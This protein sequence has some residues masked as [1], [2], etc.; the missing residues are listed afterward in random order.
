MTRADTKVFAVGPYVMGFTTS[1]RMGQLL[2]YR[3]TTRAPD[4]WDVDRFMATDFI[5]DVRTALRGSGW[6]S[7]ENGQE[8][9]GQFLVGVGGRLY[10]IHGD[11][12]I[13]RSAHGYDAVGCGQDLALGALRA[14]RAAGLRGE[15]RALVALDAAATFSAG[16][17]EPFHVV[18][19]A[20]AA[21]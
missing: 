9:G 5:D 11:F 21:A 3:L 12:Q 16:V 20:G 7:T 18:A 2:R 17:A 6:L 10:A 4:T 13:A 1:F 15:D 8:R 14:T 19:D